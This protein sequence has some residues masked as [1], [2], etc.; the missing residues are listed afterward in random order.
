[1][2]VDDFVFVTPDKV[3]RED[4]HE[5]RQDKKI[6]LVVIQQLEGA[7]LRFGTIR[8]GNHEKRHAP[9]P[10]QRFQIPAIGQNERRLGLEAARFR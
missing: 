9:R 6:N 8:P 1:M 4:L 7:L 3:R 5:S 2:D 10:R